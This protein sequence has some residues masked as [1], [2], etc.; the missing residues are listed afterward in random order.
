MHRQ[1]VLL[2]HNSSVRPDSQNASI[3]NRNPPNFS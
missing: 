3:W 2:Y 1:A